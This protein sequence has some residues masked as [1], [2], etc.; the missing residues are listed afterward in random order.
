M[1]ITHSPHPTDSS[2][3]YVRSVDFVQV[4][5]KIVRNAMT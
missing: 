2:S 4:G 3:A 1:H 5:C